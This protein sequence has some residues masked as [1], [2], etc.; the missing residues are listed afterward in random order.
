MYL[1]SYNRLYPLTKEDLKDI[2]Q[3][4]YLRKAHSLWIEKEHYIKG[5]TRVDCFL[6]SEFSMLEYYS[7]NWKEFVEELAI[8]L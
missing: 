7:N 2:V 6:E 1:D 8:V 4:Y 5:S 3:F